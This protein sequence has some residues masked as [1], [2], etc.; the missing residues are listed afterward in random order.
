MGFVLFIYNY[1][2]C[3]CWQFCWFYRDEMRLVMIFMTIVVIYRSF[4][5]GV[6]LTQK[7]TI[8]SILIFIVLCCLGVFYLNNFFLLYVSYEVSLIPIIY[9]IV[10]W[11]VYPERS[12]RA[13]ILFTY[14]SVITLPFMGVLFF[15]FGF[16][17]SFDFLVI[18]GLINF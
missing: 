12:L 2:L 6:T 4:I 10:V 13:M 1:S 7:E 9:I 16:F 18:L 15:L 14:T 5:W 3:S 11:G 17:G 8:V